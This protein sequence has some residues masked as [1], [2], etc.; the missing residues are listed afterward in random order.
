MQ[1][2]GGTGGMMS[3][4]SPSRPEEGT[5]GHIPVMAAGDRVRHSV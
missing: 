2:Y 5:P 4:A 3:P 1:S